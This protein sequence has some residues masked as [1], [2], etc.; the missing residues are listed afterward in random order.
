MSANYVIGIDLG[1][2]NSVL[3][4]APLDAESPEIELLPIPQLVAPGTL[5]SHTTLPS[6]LY[7]ATEHETKSKAYDLPWAKKRDFVVG[8]LARNQAAAMPDRTVGAAKSWL[9][10]SRVD[11]N[12]PILPEVASEDIPKIS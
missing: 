10:Y 2:T 6:F 5:E 3:A 1:T 11:R 4:Y 8:R 12:A 7:L 9:C